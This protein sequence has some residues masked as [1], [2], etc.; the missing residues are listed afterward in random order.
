M[1]RWRAVR[2]R[3]GR[4]ADARRRLRALPGD[5]RRHGPHRGGR[6][7]RPHAE[8]PARRWLGWLVPLAAAATAVA[9]WVAVPRVP[10]ADLLSPVKEESGAIAQATP[11]QPT[12]EP[13]AQ[14]ARPAG[15]AEMRRE[16]EAKNEAQNAAKLD[17]KKRS[18]DE[19]RQNKERDRFAMRD[20]AAAAA[21]P[22]PT[23][24]SE[25]T[26][27]Q[28]GAT[29]AFIDSVEVVS[30]DPQVRWRIRAARLE[31][32]LGRRHDVGCRDDRCGGGAHH[33]RGA[34]RRPSAG[35]SGARASSCSRRMGEPGAGSRSLKRQICQP[36][37][38]LTRGRRQLRPLTAANSP[39][40]TR[41]RPGSAAKNGNDLGGRFV[42]F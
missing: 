5:R 37:G 6:S 12:A 21:P 36:S 14:A 16:A 33:R 27:R 17:A 40:R 10:P 18:D 26:T 35:S 38:P 28:L 13:K 25:K 15:P 4:R 11:A 3:A 2:Q 22:P 41:A 1:G 42:V 34:I 19:A 9:I 32:T 8:R 29:Q 31:K 24:A 7:S 20:A 30:P 39:R 23:V